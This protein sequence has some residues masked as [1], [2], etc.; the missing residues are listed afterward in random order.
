[1]TGMEDPGKI[2]P[3]SADP[4]SVLPAGEK[5]EAEALHDAEAPPA[6]MKGQEPRFP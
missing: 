5:G 4:E 2:D 1:M 3:E 6:K